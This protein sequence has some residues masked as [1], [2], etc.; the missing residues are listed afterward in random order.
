MSSLPQDILFRNRNISN[1]NMV[2][3]NQFQM[4]KDLG[5]YLFF[6]RKYIF[7]KVI[8]WYWIPITCAQI[9]FSIMAILIIMYFINNQVL[10]PI[11]EMSS[12]TEF[13]LNPENNQEHAQVFNDLVEKVKLIEKRFT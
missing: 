1:L 11:K 7:D 12:M 5:L 8:I 9:G 10:E 2:F 6:M 3:L 13:I 4:D